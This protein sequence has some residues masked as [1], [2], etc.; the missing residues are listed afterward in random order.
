LER[1]F[2]PRWPFFT[3]PLVERLIGVL[4]L[5]LALIVALPIPFGNMI[6]AIIIVMICLGMIEQDGLVLAISAL[7]TCI[8]VIFFAGAI[9][10]LF[11]IGF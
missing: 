4:L 8:F 3:H 5:L 9:A 11:P 2:K 7:S 1:F 6:P 10:T